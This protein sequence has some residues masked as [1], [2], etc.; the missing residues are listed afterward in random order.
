MPASASAEMP[1]SKRSAKA[2]FSTSVGMIEIRLALPQRSPMPFSVPWIWRTPA[3]TAASEL[4][5]AWPVSS[6]AWM[7]RWSPGMP[8]AITLS[9]MAR[10]S[11]G[12]VPPLVSHS[13]T[14]RAPAS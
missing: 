11:D 10:T 12:C 7:P 14:Q 5:T 13:T 8:E 3:S 1:V 9:T 6:W 4:A 2:G